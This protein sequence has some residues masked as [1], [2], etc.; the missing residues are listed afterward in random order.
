MAILILE[1]QLSRYGQDVKKDYCIFYASIA[2]FMFSLFSSYLFDTLVH[3]RSLYAGILQFK[4]QF[5]VHG[6]TFFG[7]LF[8][9]II[10]GALIMRIYGINLARALNILTPS[11]IFGHA[12]G[13]IG[14]FLGGCCYGKVIQI[15]N[16]SIKLPVQLIESFF[17]IL[18]GLGIFKLTKFK[19]RFFVYI[20]S[21]GLF[22]FIVEFLR[23]D[24]RGYIII[25]WLSPSQIISLGILIIG[26]FIY[27]IRRNRN[28]HNGRFCHA[29]A[30]TG[31]VRLT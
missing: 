2:G 20:S 27:W 7:G 28:Y 13:R 18:L 26:V 29:R 9:G 24:D 12:V 14:C 19:N 23:D 11:I 5:N 30:R 22:R 6:F 8:G 10:F 25:T 16:L 21:Y 1:N 4:G 31:P 3:K 15:G 17:L